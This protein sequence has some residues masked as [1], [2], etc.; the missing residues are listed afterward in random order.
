[1]G[2]ICRKFTAEFEVESVEL[3]IRSGR[4]VAE[5]ARDFGIG[6]G[7]LGNWVKAAKKYGGV[8][9][10]SLVTSERA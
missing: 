5:I 7:A 9:K 8:K 2:S 6:N 3:L 10:K 4:S 1:M